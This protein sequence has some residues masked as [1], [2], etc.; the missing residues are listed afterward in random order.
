[1]PNNPTLQDILFIAI[2]P[3]TRVIGCPDGSSKEVDVAKST[4]EELTAQIAEA[5][6]NI[7][8]KPEKAEKIIDPVSGTTINWQ[9]EDRNLLRMQ[10]RKRLEE[11][12]ESSN[13]Q[14]T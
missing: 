7:I 3:E 1:M 8:G 12:L 2:P 4:R 11:F 5:I 14:E 13:D 6:E 10:Q 9:V